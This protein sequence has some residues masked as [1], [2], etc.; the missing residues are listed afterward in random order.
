[1][2]IAH[3]SDTHLGHSQFNLEEREED[4]Y[5]AFAQ[6]IDISIR[7]GV[8]AVIL[9]GDIFHTP[10]PEGGAIVKFGDQLKKLKER[11]IR[12]FFVL[13]EHDVSRVRG[14]PVLF[15]FHNLGFATYLGNGKLHN[16]DDALLMGFDKFR[17]SE[18]DDLLHRLKD[19]D[20]QVK[21]FNGHK[22]LVLHQ[23]LLDFNRYAGEIA[24][25]DLP[26]NFTYYAM[27]HYHDRH[28]QRFDRL[29]GPLVYPG[30]I[31]T[32][33]SEGI[34]ESEKGFYIVDLSAAEPKTHWHKL[35]IRPQIGVSVKYAELSA[36]LDELARKVSAFPRKPVVHVK[37]SGKDIDSKNVANMLSRL[38]N[39]VLHYRWDIIDES[40][41]YTVLDERPGDID[42][43]LF[44]L[45]KKELGNE[46]T[47]RFAIKELLPLLESGNTDEAF[48]IIWENYEKSV[49]LF[50]GDRI[51]RETS[52]G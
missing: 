6:A 51:V 19:A 40:L 50:N 26:A 43:E 35:D 41:S 32:T 42:N 18:T 25:N 14:V 3:L 49:K 8:K 21:T 28:E 30:S 20:E 52:V 10:K 1:M 11:D 37:V 27:G 2:L 12:V 46:E 31:E 15:A 44:E 16:F 34:K 22:I 23:G 9:A 36:K 24:S 38:A 29:G 33:S 17:A 5:N 48:S 45:A 4:V 13:G 47:A 39:I 7:E